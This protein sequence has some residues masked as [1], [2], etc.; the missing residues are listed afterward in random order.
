MITAIDTMKESRDSVR[1]PL[2]DA[3]MEQHVRLAAS[4]NVTHITVDTPYDFP[5]YMARWV[6]S[7]RR[8]GKAI[9][10]RCAFNAWEGSYDTTPTMTP[11]DFLRGIRRFI[12]ANRSF[13]RPGDILDPLPEPE[14]GPYWARTSQ[15]GDSW[16]WK[17]APNATT[18]E[19][20]RFFIDVTHAADEALKQTGIRGVTTNIRSTN[21]YIAARPTTLYLETAKAMGRVTIDCYVGQEPDITPQIALAALKKEIE[22]VYTVRRLPLLLG[23]YGYSTKGLVG[24]EQQRAVLK[25]QFDFL[26][27][28]PYLAGINYWHGAGYPAPDRYNGARLFTGT[29]GAWTLRPAARDLSALYADLLRRGRTPA[30][31]QR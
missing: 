11:G 26:E 3:Q 10:F 17:D 20:N 5:D 18:K 27:T 23:E 24:D 4:L 15:H 30:R 19:Y 25:P 1:D 28:L 29:R 9:W 13:F 31:K 12:G 8:T 21:P 6:R 22:A 16:T 7:V 14:N 2:T